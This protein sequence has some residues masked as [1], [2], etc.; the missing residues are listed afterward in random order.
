MK[1][2]LIELGFWGAE[3]RGDPAADYQDA[4]TLNR[5]ADAK[6]AKDVFLVSMITTSHSSARQVLIFHGDHE[7]LLVVA[8][9]YPEAICLAALAL[10]RL[11][12]D[13]PE[14]AADPQ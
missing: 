4:T 11:L 14:C 3:E 6:L 13:H 7:Y 1:F 10:P 8:D 5:R 2:K 12:K 9:N